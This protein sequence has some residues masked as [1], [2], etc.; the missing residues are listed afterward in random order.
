MIELTKN[1]IDKLKMVVASKDLFEY[2]K[3]VDSEEFYNE[4]TAPYLK[5]ICDAIQEFEND[6]NEALIITMPPRHGK[7][8][9]VNNAVDWLLGKNPKYKIM[10]GSYNTA[11]SRRSS[12]IVRDKIL[13]RPDTNRIVFSQ[14]FPK[15]TI[16]DG[17]GSIDNWGVTGNQEDNY[18]AT[19]P[20]AGSTG[21]GCDFLI[22]D[23]TIKNK[24]EAYNKEILRKIFED[25][26]QD[27]LYSRLEGKRKIIVVMTRW[28]TKD[29]AGQLIQ[30]FKE[31]G[32]KY[33][34]I[35]KKAYNP[36]TKQMLNPS[37][38]NKEQYDLLVQTIGEDIVRANYDQE[39]IDLKGKLYTHFLTYNP[40]DIRTVDNPTGTIRFKDIRARADT[41]DQGE[42]YL[43]MVIYG[44]SYDNKAYILDIYYTQE[45]ME[46]TEKEAA[47]RLLKY[48]PYVF[49][50]ESNN[51]G[52]GWSRAVEKEYKAMG[53]TKTIFK[54]YT[55]TLNKEARILS[56][57]S[58][59]MNVIYFPM[60]WNVRYK[61]AY[62]SI[63]EYQRQGKNEHD[64]FEDNITSVA[65]ELDS[66][67]GI[68]F[69]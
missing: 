47:K 49:R 20:N 69:G 13:E 62:N 4:E 5:E 54:P 31:Q 16:K 34:I 41:A 40:A 36:E 59:V 28:A 48:N 7:T 57:A 3:Y 22:L 15:V 68:K 63:N 45:P 17:S 52:R 32:R 33:R 44:V 21:I 1:Q 51:G 64:D 56:N 23:D 35:S 58:S 39:P 29:I 27:T 8:R 38:L 24:Y 60:D 46:V 14:V 25:W 11:L 26:F 12:K 2:C 43:S 65:E 10:E 42:D 6:D 19:A 50:A 66:G 53:G 30:M 9:T 18:L 37:I 61:E 55:Q 67:L